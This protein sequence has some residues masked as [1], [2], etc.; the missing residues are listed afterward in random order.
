MLRDLEGNRP[1]E[2]DHVVG[3]MVRRGRRHGL[4]LPVLECAWAALQSYEAKRTA[5]LSGKPERGER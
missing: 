3:D 1:T 5:G 2:A 4:D